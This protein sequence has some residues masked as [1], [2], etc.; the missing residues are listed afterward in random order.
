[1]LS[2]EFGGDI[3]YNGVNGMGTARFK[4]IGYRMTILIFMASVFIYDYEWC[5][6]VHKR[7]ADD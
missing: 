1:M 7:L 3:F 4:E 5:E 6:G 2:L